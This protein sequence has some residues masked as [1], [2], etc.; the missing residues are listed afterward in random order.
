MKWIDLH[1]SGSLY[2][3]T[4]LSSTFVI[5]EGAACV[6]HPD[7][8][9]RGWLRPHCWGHC[10]WDTCP[11]AGHLCRVYTVPGCNVA[12]G[13]FQNLPGPGGWVTGRGDCSRRCH[14][15]QD[16]L[17][18]TRQYLEEWSRWFWTTKK[19]KFLEYLLT[20]LCSVK[21]IS[22]DKSIRDRRFLLIYVIPI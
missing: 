9:N 21:L 3:L 17:P 13:W 18:G 16:H 20:S 2:E 1:E 22:K 14:C 10:V 4:I 8:R 12:P 7:H 11:S 5:P 19:V 15:S 6:W